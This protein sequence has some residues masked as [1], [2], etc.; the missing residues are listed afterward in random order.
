MVKT[1]P[2]STKLF[3]ETGMSGL[4]WVVSKT[5][6]SVLSWGFYIM[7]LILTV[8]YFTCIL[9]LLERL[10]F[11]WIRAVNNDAVDHCW[12]C[13]TL[14]TVLAISELFVS[15]RQKEEG[16]VCHCLLLWNKI[17]LG[18]PARAETVATLCSWSGYYTSS[19]I[20]SCSKICSIFLN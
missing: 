19:A 13:N 15:S 4:C 1:T 12:N 10:V 17:F 20:Q 11:H 16:T 3:W 7:P 2:F 18:F 14:I 5:L 8:F 9:W 6:S